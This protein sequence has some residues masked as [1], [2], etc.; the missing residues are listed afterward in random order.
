MKVACIGNM[1]N[2]FFSL[3]RFL[4][5]LGVD[6][7][8]LLLDNEKDHFLPLA[9]T[10]N[11]DYNDYTIRL[12]WG[13]PFHFLNFTRKLAD[14]IK[15]DIDGYDVII[16]CETVP[17]FLHRIDRSVDIFIP[18][19]EDLFS[20]PFFDLLKKERWKIKVKAFLLHKYQ[21]R[22]IQNVR[23][24]LEDHAGDGVDEVLSRLQLKGTRINC[25]TPMVYTPDYNPIAIK[26]FY[27]RS[28]WHEKFKGIRES[29][30]LVIFHQAR[31]IWK[32]TR[33]L[34]C[35]ANDNLFRGFAKFL[36]HSTDANACIVT[37]D[38]GRDVGA[39]K[40]LIQSLGIEDKVCWLPLLPRKEIMVGLSLCD[41]GTGDFE[42]GWSSNGV[43]F[44]ILA[45]AKP[46]MHYRNDSL[47]DDVYPELYPLINVKSADDI[48]NS[49]HDYMTQ[50]AYY[51]SMGER[52]RVWYQQYGV[53]EP[54]KIFMDIIVGSGLPEKKEA[55]QQAK[56][57]SINIVDGLV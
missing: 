42:H 2:M 55:L 11:D 52:G 33:E 17:A 44:E 46:L 54:L 29:H 27:R 21:R 24:M 6:V 34:A 47:Y 28:K 9:D 18:H 4:R 48:A 26:Q 41:I 1:N 40:K 38:Y 16:G 19:G 53:D 49:L 50:R 45:M 57:S 5:G 51:R 3:V 30:D 12:E 15:A 8:L 10:F 35:K 37:C 56:L 43:I 22:G 39:T 7:N 25:G 13:H 20:Y 32:D 31:H 36:N 23:Y 14:K